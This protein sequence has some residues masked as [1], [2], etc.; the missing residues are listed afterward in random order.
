MSSYLYM[1]L[2]VSVCGGVCSVLAAGGFEK[3]VKYVASLACICIIITPFRDI[4]VEG[5]LTSLPEYVPTYGESQQ[6]PYPIAEEMTEKRAEE[7]IYQILLGKFGIKAVSTDIKIDWESEKDAVI[8]S[9]TVTLSTTDMQY[10]A[11]AEEYLSD[12]LGGEVRIVEE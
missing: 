1:L 12:Q 3:Y 2:T 8:R 9:I 5:L 11:E 7:Y 6:E 10:S 4:D